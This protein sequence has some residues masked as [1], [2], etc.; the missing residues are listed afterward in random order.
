MVRNRK[1]VLVFWI[2]LLIVLLPVVAKEGSVLSLSQG[3][4]SG[5]GLQSAEASDI[6]S[7]EFAKSVANNSLVIVITGHNVT[8][9]AVQSSLRTLVSD[10]EAKH[11]EGVQNITT[12][13]SV[14]YPIL[15]GTDAGGQEALA[16]ANETAG[17]IYGV[18]AIYLNVWST[19]YNQTNSVAVADSTAYNETASELASSNST[20]YQELTS[21][22]LAGF[23]QSYTASF[24]QPGTQGLAPLE[25]ASL[26]INESAPQFLAA[27][28]PESAGFGDALVKSYSLQT[29]LGP[30][31]NAKLAEFAQSF[32]ADSSALSPTF[33]KAAMGLGPKPTQAQLDSLAGGVAS[34]PSR[35]SAGPQI[36]SL[37][38][39]FVS[40]NDNTTLVSVT[41][42]ISSTDNLLAIRAVIAG[43]GLSSEVTP[44][45]SSS[46]I[47]AAQVTGGDAISNDFG[48]S[49]TSDLGIILPVTI[50]LLIV[51]TGLFFRSVVTPFLAL[52]SI[53][54]ALGISQVFVVLAGTFIA[55]VDFTIPT[56]L[57]TIVIGVGTDYSVF[58]ISRYREGRA[59]GLDSTEA[60]VTSVT[61]A[62]ESIAT[63]GA[64]VIISFFALAFTSVQFLRTMGLVVGAGVLVALA[65][66]LTLVPAV[67][68]MISESVFWPTSGRR[69][70][71][72]SSRL[73][74]KLERRSG[75]FSKAGTFSVKH[76]KVLIL[77]AVLVSV[78]AMAVYA[79]TPSS[80]DLLAGAPKNLESISAS[81]HLTDAFGAGR[82]DPTYVVVSFAHPLWNGTRFNQ[83]EMATLQGITG[84]LDSNPDI[85]N[86]TG[87]T[88]PY[89]SPVDYSSASLQSG[90]TAQDAQT[91]DAMLQSIGKDNSTALL[92]VA[93]RI[94]PS[95]TKGLDDASAIRD[96]LA[97]YGPAQGVS[98]AVLGGAAGST[99][100]TRLVS[101][102][103]FD[104]I[105]P[106][107][108]VGVGLVLFVV[109]DSL[110]L[111]IFAV[112][113]VLMGIVWTVALTEVVFKAL[114]NS[115][116]LYI[117]PI[118]LFVTLLGLGMD[119]NIFILT[120]VREE[121][122]K[123]GSRGEAV[124]RAIENTGATITAAAVILAGSLGALMLSS[125]L[126]LQEVGFAFFFAIL[127]DALF[128][129]TYLVPAVLAFLGRWSWFN[130]VSVLKR[131]RD[132]HR[133]RQAS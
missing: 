10:I 127:V 125:D 104:N 122:V 25:R 111:P 18:P 57:L 99:Y 47:S 26:A 29:F 92:S 121:S 66:S 33:V 43:M 53:G 89:G 44:S 37:V 81:N 106:L 13:Y 85:A 35:Y 124:I 3:S 50:G 28:L 31:S 19:V 94:D 56:I 34:D 109:L 71:D 65:I 36:G 4:A 64:T 15:N 80:Y 96:H 11:L 112:I 49:T 123:G 131:S 41:E 129:R 107:V 7:A 58:I 45:S 101:N 72:Y 22:L 102:G 5:S 6:I 91:R 73:L 98:Q 20:D 17:L 21:H 87:P 40:P 119:Y 90:A 120:R 128:V 114:F 2:L 38:S 12:V 60:L 1:K 77:V 133:E 42:G 23:N 74:S 30:A 84:Y 126:L 78:P 46:P 118:F 86:V 62:G 83:A 117:I 32:V 16:N 100:D 88:T 48:G 76:A 93:F 24:A 97:T 63:S 79:T 67:V 52:T 103:Q 59:R 105:V 108:A 69:F 82:L 61:W 54:V 113:S 51:A 132:L 75:Y 68:K 55:K 130:P 115:P 9:P 8:T 70:A 95:S 116:L 27:Y 14:L 39:S 110:V